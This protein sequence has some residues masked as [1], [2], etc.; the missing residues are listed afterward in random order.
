VASASNAIIDR[1]PR[2]GQKALVA[3][4]ETVDLVLGAEVHL[5]D[6][7]PLQVYF[8]LTGCLSLISV[9]PGMP[10][11]EVG[12]VGREGM[13]CAHLA[14]GITRMPLLVIV[15]G[16]GS[17][18]R[19]PVSV[20]HEQLASTPRLGK[21]LQRYAGSQLA[22]FATAAPCLRF[23][24]ISPRLARWLLMTQDRV[25]TPRFHATHEFLSCML[26]VRRAGV[27]VAAGALQQLG[28][29]RY[30]RGEVTV[31]DRA[32][33]EDAACSCYAADREAFSDAMGDAAAG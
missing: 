1:L 2:A 29:I 12:M 28:A 8:P 4:C 26:G 20:L 17:A 14:L 3:L 33:L 10:G 23:H 6:A 18:L 22:Q 15:Q 31:L 27:T 30:E 11:V 13:S 32:R 19:L 16:A 9:R 5:P 24:S 7:P 25:G 21:I